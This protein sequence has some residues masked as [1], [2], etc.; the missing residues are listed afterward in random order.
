MKLDQLVRNRIR[1]CHRRWS[2]VVVVELPRDQRSI[3]LRSSI[4]PDNSRRTEISPREFLLPRPDDTHW[5]SRSLRQSRRFHRS[6]ALMLPAITRT[7]IRHQYAYLR[8]IDAKSIRKFV[9]HRK[10][11]LRSRPNRQSISIPLR[12]RS[13]RFQR[14][15]RDVLNRISMI[16][17]H[18]R[19]RHRLIGRANH[20]LITHLRRVEVL[21]EVIEQI[22]GRW[23]FRNLPLR[24]HRPNC[25]F[26]NRGVRRDHAN[27]VAVAYHFHCGNFV[28][29]ARI[30]LVKLRLES[31]RPKHF[32]VKHSRT[33]DIRWILMFPGND[34]SSIN[35]R[36]RLANKLPFRFDRLRRI[37][38]DRLH[39]VLAAGKFAIGKQS[40]SL[41]VRDYAIPRQKGFRIFLPALRGHLH[42][43]L[44]R[45]C[46]CCPHLR[47]HRRR[48]PTS[49]RSRIP[50]NMI[51]I[52]HQE[53]YRFHRHAQL[54]RNLLRKRCPD[55]LSDL[56][57]PCESRDSAVFADV[58]PRREVFRKF[59]PAKP[60][61]RFLRNRA[62]SSDADHQTSTKKL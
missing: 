40:F 35:L 37:G 13:A 8:R 38:S 47:S 34:L 52:A 62:R 33:R 48:R 17:L 14:S 1:R 25:L 56:Y 23:L 45:G 41:R 24:L 22:L 42:Q 58:Q 10:R 51:C 15:M 29:R 3:A 44:A 59:V 39:Q 30:Q 53:R 2:R 61:T 49:D 20:V 7:C 28:R 57:L 32:A 55:V 4:H 9:A 18:L 5:F 11:T 12:N 27:E 16:E 6:I 19:R 31:R 60:A 26:R 54:F 46:R 43:H 21:H 50:R 36:Q